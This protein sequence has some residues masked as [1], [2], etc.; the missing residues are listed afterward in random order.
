[1]QNSQV[2]NGCVVIAGYEKNG[3]EV[4]VVRK[5]NGKYDVI[6]ENMVVQPDHDE[7]GIIRY[8]SHCLHNAFYLLEKK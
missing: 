1:M 3:K 4:T 7:E 5:A 6:E 8:L 2:D